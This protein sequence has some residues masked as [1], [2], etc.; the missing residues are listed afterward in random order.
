MPRLTT[1]RTCESLP[2]ISVAY[3]KRAGIFGPRP[4]SFGFD[5]E[6]EGIRERIWVHPARMLRDRGI[7]RGRFGVLIE[8]RVD[9]ERRECR[10]GFMTTPQRP[11]G[12]TRHWFLCPGCWRRCSVLYLT[13]NILCR[14]CLGINYQSQRTS[15]WT[16]W[17]RMERIRQRLRGLPVGGTQS[18]CPDRPSGAWRSTYRRLKAEYEAA[19]A[20]QWRVDQPADQGRYR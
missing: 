1:R 16:G 8:R 9:S 12:G 10:V 15:A 19:L 13:Y 18:P 20:L 3:V 14:K 5:C 6:S 17:R 4:Q 2:Q 7:E 11:F